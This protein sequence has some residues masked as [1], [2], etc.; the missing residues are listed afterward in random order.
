MAIVVFLCACWGFNQVAVKLAMPDVPPL[1]QGALRSLL[2]GGVVF[3]W[4]LWRG[5]ALFERDGTLGAGLFAGVLFGIEFLLIYQGLNYTTASR[6]VLFIY[7]APFFVVLGVRLFL[8]ADRFGPM[9]WT[10]LLLSFAGMVVAF[11]LPTPSADPRQLTGDLMMVGAAIAWA[12]TTVV[13]KGSALNRVSPE[14]TLLYQLAVSVPMMAA[15]AWLAGEQ[16][17]AMPG[18]MALGAVG[19]QVLVVSVTY[20]MW[21]AMIVRYSAG[22]LSAFTFL[23]PLCGVAAGH[24]IL[25]DPLTP[26]FVLAVLLVAAG[27][28]LVNRR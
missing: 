20:A 5:R 23:T 22:R 18:A 17:A 21:F 15:G 24:W 9:Q 28:V 26:A 19:Y 10:G 13:I 12:A 27:L 3:V 8:P 4:C 6:A 14:K 11:G 7:L 16:I 25:G 2:A 1:T